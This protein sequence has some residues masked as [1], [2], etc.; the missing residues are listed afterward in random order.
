MTI[1]DEQPDHDERQGIDEELTSALN[2]LKQLPQTEVAAEVGITDRRLR[3]IERGRVKKPRRETR[4]AL[5][6]LADQVRSG[7]RAAGLQPTST[8]GKSHKRGSQDEGAIPYGIAIVVAFLAIFVLGAIS[9]RNPQPFI[10]PI[11]P[12]QE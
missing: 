6:W 7:R 3:D 5:L 9:S 4:D 11:Q 1:E 10:W 2:I 12:N 8:P